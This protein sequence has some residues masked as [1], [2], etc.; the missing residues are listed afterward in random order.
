M[1]KSL[2]KL[3]LIGHFHEHKN[4]HH[5]ETSFTETAKF[6]KF[7]VVCQMLSDYSRLQV[8]DILNVKQERKKKKKKLSY[9]AQKL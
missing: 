4:S 8:I 7:V 2:S 6:F 1:K 9:S 3:I 5:F